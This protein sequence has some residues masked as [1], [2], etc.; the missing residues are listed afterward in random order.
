[1]ILKAKEAGADVIVTLPNP[2]D[3]IAIVKQMKELAVN[4]KVLVTIRA[5]DGPNWPQNLKLD[6]DFVLLMTG[7]SNDINLPGVK[8]MNA[9]HLARF[10]SPAT[11]ITGPAYNLLF[12]LADAIKRAKN[13]DRDGIRNALAEA[14]MSDSLIGPV[15][16]RPDGSSE[17]L[18]V[19]SQYQG[20]KTVS[21]W[22]PNTAAT[23]VI[24][25]APAFADRK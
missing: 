17:V 23:K 10:N 11:P 3:G 19:V 22:P 7:W 14:N 15:K 4:P 24:Y 6:G 1:M 20:G 21:V 16:F 2:P 25:P 9:A 8:E 18:T 13:L 5:A 12:V